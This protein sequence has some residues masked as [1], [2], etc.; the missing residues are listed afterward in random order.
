LHNDLETLKK[1]I[2]QLEKRTEEMEGQVGNMD[3]EKAVL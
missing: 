2:L 3:Y 1:K